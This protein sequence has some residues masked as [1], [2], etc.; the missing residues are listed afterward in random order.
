MNFYPES[1]RRNFVVIAILTLTIVT[2]CRWS[3]AQEPS[4]FT[5]VA[6]DQRLNEQLPMSLEFR[7]Q[8]G[9]A[10]RLEQYFGKKP[11]ILSLVYYECPMLCTLELNGLV[12]SLK[13][14]NLSA[15]TDFT[16]LT[17]SFDPGETTELAAKKRRSYLAQYDRTGAELGWHFLTSDRESIEALCDAVGFHYVYDPERDEYAHASGIVVLTPNG[18]IAR[19]FFGIEFPARDL[20]LGLVEASSGKIGSATDQLLLLCY[21]YDPTTGR[22]GFLVM[23]AVR[24]GGLAT[25]LVLGGFIGGTAYRERR[26]RSPLEE[27]RPRDATQETHRDE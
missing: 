11:V 8:S 6:F 23:S 18:K 22:Y 15:G 24:L 9:Q 25:V 4:V 7:D 12:K 3:E 5:E 26:R 27:R 2:L 21:G 10:V 13:T 20:R 19:Y 17:V 14:L 16:L 1:R